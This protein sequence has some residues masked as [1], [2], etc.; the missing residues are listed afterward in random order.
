VCS[1][2]VP[3]HSRP[4]SQVS[5]AM[6]RGD[7]WVG[8]GCILAHDDW[9]QNLLLQVMNQTASLRLASNGKSASSLHQSKAK[10]RGP[11]LLLGLLQSLSIILCCLRGAS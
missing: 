8:G 6:G 5:G 11:P 1:Q 2:Q 3:P 7:R 10:A 9:N 4:L